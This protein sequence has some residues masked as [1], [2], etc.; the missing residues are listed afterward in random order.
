MS[1]PRVRGYGPP[2]LSVALVHGGPGAPGAMAPGARGA[3]G[4]FYRLLDHEPA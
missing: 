1:R 3:R 2:P 4:E